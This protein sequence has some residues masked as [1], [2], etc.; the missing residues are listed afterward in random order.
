M[1]GSIWIFLD[2]RPEPIP[3]LSPRGL[4]V[5]ARN[6]AH[7]APDLTAQA[8]RSLREMILDG[9][10]TTQ[11]RLSHRNLSRDLGIG[12]SPVRDALLQL[13]AEGLIEHRPSSGIY[14]REI[15][16]TELE[17]ICE[18]R[19]VNEPFA[20]ERAASFAT[21]AQLARMLQICDAMKVIA[22]KPD[23]GR[24]FA[25]IEHRAEF[26]RLDWEF[27]SEVLEAS[28]NTILAKLLSN[29]Q[30]LALTFAWDLEHGSAEWFA[31]IVCETERLHRTILEAIRRHDPA[32]ARTAM[33]THIG[34][35]RLE[36][37]EHVATA[38]EQAA[39]G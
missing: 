37:P 11:K 27:D 8:Y 32:T 38:R 34:W 35:A 23:P 25:T 26:C 39:D 18:L 17:Q 7:S 10:V 6:R 24:W 22:G 2:F 31:S 4:P 13:E 30:I 9:K 28:G 14:L 36:I 1:L 19:A 15:S 33:D 16:S 21:A 29:A 3:R 5:A 20:A 12:R